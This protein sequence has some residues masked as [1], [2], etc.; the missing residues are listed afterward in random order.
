MCTHT[1][2]HTDTH[3]DTRTHRCIS[4]YIYTNTFIATDHRCTHIH[5]C[6]QTQSHPHT[7]TYALHTPRHTH[8]DTWIDAC[9]AVYTLHKHACAQRYTCRNT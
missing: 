9:I 8:T 2:Q 4:F 7:Y 6:T 5:M 3:K 1:I